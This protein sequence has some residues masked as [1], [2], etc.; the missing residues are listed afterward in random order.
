MLHKLTGTMITGHKIVRKTDKN[1]T[2]KLSNL[3]GI[4]IQHLMVL[5]PTG[6]GWRVL[7]LVQ[8]LMCPTIVDAP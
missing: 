7:D 3:C 2:N 4:L 6:Q 1:V 8:D 5:I